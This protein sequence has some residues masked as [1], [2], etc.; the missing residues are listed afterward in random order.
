MSRWTLF[1]EFSRREA[2]LTIFETIGIAYT[3]L[4]TTF[5]T[6]ELIYCA[7]KGVNNLRHLLARGQG[8][9]ERRGASTEKNEKKL[10]KI[11]S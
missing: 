5:F 7:V 11:T 4:A 3:I 1:S 8:G 6:I 9:P 2:A 10:L